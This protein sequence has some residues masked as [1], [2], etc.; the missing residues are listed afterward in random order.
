[1][2]VKNKLKNQRTWP[3]SSR[4]PVRWSFSATRSDLRRDPH[5]R[6][7][8]RTAVRT[9]SAQ[10]QEPSPQE[11]SP[12]SAA[13][14]TGASA[15]AASAGAG[16]GAS[17]APDVSTAAG[18]SAAGASSEPPHAP[19][20][21]RPAAAASMSSLFLSSVFIVYF[22]QMRCAESRLRDH[23]YC[24]FSRQKSGT[25]FERPPATSGKPRPQSGV[26]L[27]QSK[28]DWEISGQ[29]W[30]GVEARRDADHSPQLQREELPISCVACHDTALCLVCPRLFPT[31]RV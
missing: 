26:T 31:V 21:A 27:P 7:L 17:S 10:L 4:R 18:S 28:T 13:P 6:E 1:M 19:K 5:S 29:L 2:R 9:T 12:P 25:S 8:S 30:E 15:G 16:A 23:A 20:L 24:S 14:S 3:T 22:L 11:P